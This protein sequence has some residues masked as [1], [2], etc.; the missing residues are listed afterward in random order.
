MKRNLEYEH[1]FEESEERYMGF[2]PSPLLELPLWIKYAR[3]CKSLHGRLTTS[4]L[5]YHEQLYLGP[6]W[7]EAIESVVDAGY[8]K[9]ATAYESLEFYNLQELRKLLT[10][11]GL[12]AS[13]NKSEVISLIIKSYSQEDLSTKLKEHYY[14]R[15]SRGEM[16]LR[17]NWIHALNHERTSP[18]DTQDVATLAKIQIEG[19]GEVYNPS[20]IF[21]ELLKNEFISEV[22]EVSNGT[23]DSSVCYQNYLSDLISY[24]PEV[25]MHKDY[26]RWDAYLFVLCENGQTTE[27]DRLLRWAFDSTKCDRNNLIEDYL[28]H[29]NDFMCCLSLDEYKKNNLVKLATNR[30]NTLSQPIKLSPE[31]IHFVLTTLKSRKPPY[32]RSIVDLEHLG[33]EWETAINYCVN[34]SLVEIKSGDTPLPYYPYQLYELSAKGREFMNTASMNILKEQYAHLKHEITQV[35]NKDPEDLLNRAYY[36][37]YYP[38]GYKMAIKQ[39]DV[40]NAI[41][42][43]AYDLVLRT[44]GLRN[45]GTIAGFES[46]KLPE[47]KDFRQLLKLFSNDTLEVSK[48]IRQHII[49][50]YQ[51]LPFHFFQKPDLLEIVFKTINGEPLDI[52]KYENMSE[53]SSVNSGDYFR[54]VVRFKKDGSPHYVIQKNYID[55]ADKPDEVCKQ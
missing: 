5:P 42:F 51:F 25:P 26:L 10:A 4:A 49:S 3:L 27:H 30:V 55:Y 22:L 45:G 17:D 36:A 31:Q 40:E 33:C 44:S 13:G 54:L 11:H 52:R 29:I 43:K 41:R 24:F 20:L 14:C 32:K 21:Y 2:N 8:I 46:I 9:I 7:K 34:N 48:Q 18:Y 6:E 50:M 19:Q 28:G 47:T 38:E 16:F 35:F 53:F 1:K 15:T 37:H 23:V 39:K 12:K